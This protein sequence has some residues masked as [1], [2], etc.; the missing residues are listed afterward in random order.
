MQYNRI[1]LGVICQSQWRENMRNNSFWYFLIYVKR[2]KKV[3]LCAMT[4]VN[5]IYSDT[6]IEKMS[7][8]KIWPKMTAEREMT[9]IS[10]MLFLSLHWENT[11]FEEISILKPSV[12]NL[13][14]EKKEATS[15]G[16]KAMKIREN[17]S[18]LLTT[19]RWL[20][21]KTRLQL[22]AYGWPAAAESSTDF[23]ISFLLGEVNSKNVS[24]KAKSWRRLY[25]MQY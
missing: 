19:P 16:K 12:S 23:I 18:S 4:A 5:D 14:S 2:K 10:D 7:V 9:F 25:T 8:E 3:W 15:S 21:L 24:L 6:V 20:S 1:G 11:F 22:V 13:L 17:R